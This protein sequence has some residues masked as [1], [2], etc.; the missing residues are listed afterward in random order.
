MK[1]SNTQNA[2]SMITAIIVIIFMSTVAIYVLSTSAKIITETTAQYQREQAVLLA[3]SYT[4]YAIM[5]VTAN[6]SNVT[7]QCLTDIDGTIGSPNNGEGYNI[8]IRIAYIGH[9]ALIDPC[10]NT[11]ELGN[12]ITPRSPINIIVD[13]YVEYKEAD[14]PDN[15]NAQFITYHK[16]TLQKI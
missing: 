8:R 16:R 14:N 3:K 15:S 5:A 12:S 9:S 7:G 1:Y 4:E 13:A 10:A 6:E 11:R 2:F